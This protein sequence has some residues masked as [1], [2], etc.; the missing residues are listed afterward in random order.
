MVK[1]KR[2]GRTAQSKASAGR[3]DAGEG[4]QSVLTAFRILDQLRLLSRF[5][6][7]GLG[8]RCNSKPELVYV[9]DRAAWLRSIRAA[10]EELPPTVVVPAHGDPVLDNVVER[11]RLA[12]DAIDTGMTRPYCGSQ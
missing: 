1:H 10:L 6:G 4:L 2:R 12:I 3:M 9:R 8:Y 5:L 7:S 11:T